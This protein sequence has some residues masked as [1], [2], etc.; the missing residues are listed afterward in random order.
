MFALIGAK[1]AAVRSVATRL[2]DMRPVA[3][4]A[5]VAATLALGGCLPVTAPLRADPADPSVPVAPMSYRSTVAPYT[6]MRPV[7]PSAWRQRNDDV[8]PSSK[9]SR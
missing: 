4:A 5:T 3:L 1:I 8:S 7:S 9:S 2:V 6:S